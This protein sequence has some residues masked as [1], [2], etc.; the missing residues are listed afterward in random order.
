MA[1]IAK[2]KDGTTHLAYKQ[3]SFARWRGDEAARRAVVAAEP[4]P[5]VIGRWPKERLPKT[6]LPR[7][8]ERKPRAHNLDRGGMRRTWPKIGAARMC[9]SDTCY[10]VAGH[11]LSKALDDA[12]SSGRA[13]ISEPK[14]KAVLRAGTDMMR[15]F[16][17]AHATTGTRLLVG[18][19]QGSLQSGA[20]EVVERSFAAHSSICGGDEPETCHLIN[21]AVRTCIGTMI[22]STSPNAHKPTRTSASMR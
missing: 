5:A 10:H 18:T 20:A 11:N 13:G 21:G 8:A 3:K 22:C 19:G 9:T 4:D 2:M 16:R 15:Y 12:N 1:K 7:S 14:Q 17:A 6:A